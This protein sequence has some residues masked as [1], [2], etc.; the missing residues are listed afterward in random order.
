MYTIMVLVGVR[1]SGKT[2]VIENIRN[3]CGIIVLQPST[4]RTPR[5]DEK[6]EYDFRDAGSWDRNDFAW[7][8]KVNSESYGMRKSELRSIPTGDVGVTVFHPGNLQVLEDYRRQAEMEFVTVGLDTVESLEEQVRRTGDDPSRNEG[9]L[10]FNA[11]RSVVRKC[12][13]VLSGASDVVQEAVKQIAILLAKR[14]VL[15]GDAIRALVRAGTLVKGAEPQNVQPA[16]YDLRLGDTVWCKGKWIT[17]GDRSPVATIPPYSYII[18]QAL[19]EAELPKFIS[20]HY[21]VKLSL[22]FQ[23]ITLSNGPQVDPGYSGGLFCLLFNS[24]DRN[25]GI[26]RGDHFATIEFLTTSKVTEGYQGEHQLKSKPI[27]FME[28]TT[29]VSPGGTLL[30]RFEKIKK[31]W[32]RTKG[33]IISVG[34]PI[35]LGLCALLPILLDRLGDV[36]DVIRDAKMQQKDVEKTVKESQ[37]LQ[38]NIQ[39]LLDSL[40]VRID[41]LEKVSATTNNLPLPSAPTPQQLGQRIP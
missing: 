24:S 1:G 34:I 5:P 2:T 19:E 23:G 21:D 41:I 39:S 15:H 22:F 16:S 3:S 18:A 36:R 30:D 29:A 40:D 17:L 38:K 20:A 37:D 8:I 4:T 12:D 25:V 27:D 33:A 9:V 11:Q 14:G 35:V 26:R 13:V 32:T 28:A 6:N 31:S 10:A 7:T